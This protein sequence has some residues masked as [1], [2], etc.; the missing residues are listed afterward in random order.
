MSNLVRLRGVAG[1]RIDDAGNREVVELLGS[2]EDYGAA[3]A[4]VE[5]QV[6]QGSFLLHVGRQEDAA[7]S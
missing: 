1:T 5:R 3:Y 6:P 2:G 7:A 4:D